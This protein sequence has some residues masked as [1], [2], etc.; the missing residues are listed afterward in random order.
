[1]A[2]ASFASHA[3]QPKRAIG[4]LHVADLARR[5][6]VTPAT[7][8]YYARIGLLN[9]GRNTRNGYR[10]FSSE[11][12]RRVVFIRKA[13]ALGLTI[14]DIRSVIDRIERGVDACHLVVELVR[15]RLDEVHRQCT[16]LRMT[17]VRMADALARWSAAARGGRESGGLCP[18]IEEIDINGNVRS[19]D[20]RADVQLRAVGASCNHSRR[21]AMAE[22]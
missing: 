6:E 18:L 17:E 3:T 4:T 22:A 16:E 7:V 10:R 21:H 5:A 9:P 19:L 12:L 20:E 2:F 14:S 15:S 8:R 11:D 1:M 13:Q